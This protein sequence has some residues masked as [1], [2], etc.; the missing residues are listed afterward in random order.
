MP[1]YEVSNQDS[2]ETATAT[3]TRKNDTPAKK[4]GGFGIFIAIT[5]SLA[6]LAG[7][8]A[9]YLSQSSKSEQLV[10]R[11]SAIE[12]STNKLSSTLSESQDKLSF[13]E[14]NNATEL[15]SIKQS[16]ANLYARVEN[17]SQ[18]W[19]IEE[20]SQLLQLASDQLSLAG[21]I[22]GALTALTIA[23]RRIANSGS[24]ELQPAREQI[25]QDIASLQ[26]VNQIDLTG[27]VN[28]LRAVERAIS[29]L[30]AMQLPVMKK[31]EEVQSTGTDLT[32]WQRI[33]DDMSGLVKI[34]R[35][36]QQEASLLPMEKTFYLHEN[37]KALI[38]SARLGLLQRNKLVYQTN[39]LQARQS[40][41]KYV[42]SNQQ[43]MTW[44][45]DELQALAKLNPA[46]DLPDIS[47]SL[48]SLNNI[49]TGNPG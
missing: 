20:V 33:V 8:G 44:I 11:I 6:A 43:T 16:I 37:A 35:I 12:S 32:L 2:D 42:K 9:L 28:R 49:T 26:Q 45:L 38:M 24:P 39:L 36:D 41:S 7:S 13:A 47:G 19:S 29:E 31:N 34:R 18:S 10:A 17:T 22:K 30:P 40:L 23:D 4:G 3:D 48:N 1:D 25:A 14:R 21:N 5:L 15:K 27:T 46:P